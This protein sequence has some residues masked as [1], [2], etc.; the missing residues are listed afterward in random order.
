MARVKTSIAVGRFVF[1]VL[2]TMQC[3]FL[4]SF[5]AH[6]EDEGDW[7]AITLLFVPAIV[8]LWWINSTTA[9]QMEVVIFWLMYTCLGAAPLIGISFGRIGDKVESE[10][11]WNA[12]TLIMT[13]SITPLLLFMCPGVHVS[14][15]SVK[16][17]I[18]LFDGI[19]L[20]AVILDE[21]ECSHGISRP[22]KKTLIA[23]CFYLYKLSVE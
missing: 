17:L 12:S 11:F 8:M 21:N 22:L 10:G 7:Y 13:L 2:V 5:L 19:E 1:F 16:A 3:F 15:W 14:E 9:D 18:N 4:A 6:Y 23:N 20:I